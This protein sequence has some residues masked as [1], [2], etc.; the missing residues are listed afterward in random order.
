[1][2]FFI[3]QSIIQ[4]RARSQ[5]KSLGQR[6]QTMSTHYQGDP[7]QITAK[8]PSTCHTCGKKIN[9]GEHIIYWPNGKKAGHLK[10]DEDDYRHSLASFED[11]DRYNGKY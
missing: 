10:C 11:E 4:R 9:K 2:A 7:R 6:Q 5:N 1:M 8:F 3:F